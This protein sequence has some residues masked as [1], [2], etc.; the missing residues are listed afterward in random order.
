MNVMQGL[1]RADVS[2]EPLHYYIAKGKQHAETAK[3]L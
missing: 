3:F 1:P 2:G